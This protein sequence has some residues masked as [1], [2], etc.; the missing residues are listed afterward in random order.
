[1]SC[2]DNS[3]IDAASNA[4]RYALQELYF[5][6]RHDNYANYE[7]VGLSYYA[8]NLFKEAIPYFDKAISFK[9]CISGK[10]AFFRGIC[11]IN[12][13]RKPEGCASFVLAQKQE[14]PQAL[15]FYN[16]NCITSSKK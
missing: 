7:N 10:S 9:A 12:A 4:S 6:M 11:L 3:L 2:E 14:Y 5:H 13:G 16:N 8:S 1:M 15:D